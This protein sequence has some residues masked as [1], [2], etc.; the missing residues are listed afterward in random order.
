[1]Q[2]RGEDID[3]RSDIFA[4]GILIYESTTSSRLFR[5]DDEAAVMR[6]IESCK[7]EP[8]S[9]RRADYPPELE[10]IVMKALSRD[11]DKRHATAQELQLELEAFARH[12]GLVISTV[13]LAS[14]ME[15]LFPAKIHAWQEAQKKGQ[16]FGAHLAGTVEIRVE[17]VAF[18]DDK[19]VVEDDH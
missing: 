7:F 12:E 8:P 4:M 16:S 13:S 10:R 5:G 1:E 18:L 19:D 2:C 11:R 9:S 15:R 3:R 6:Q 17:E 14:Y